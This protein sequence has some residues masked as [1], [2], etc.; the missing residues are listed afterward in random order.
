MPVRLIPSERKTL[1]FCVEEGQSPGSTGRRESFWFWF[2]SY[3]P[4]LPSK[5]FWN[6]EGRSNFF[7]YKYP[8][9]QIIKIHLPSLCEVRHHYLNFLFVFTYFIWDHRYL[10]WWWLMTLRKHATPPGSWMTI[11]SLKIWRSER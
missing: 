4:L 5:F 6:P 7:T 8:C 2:Q 9:L 1:V 3:V 10:L 11:S